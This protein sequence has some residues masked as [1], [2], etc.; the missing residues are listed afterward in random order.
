M[1]LTHRYRFSAS[2]RIHVESLSG[3]ENRRL[4]GKCNNPYGHGHN[5]NLEITVEGPVDAKTGRVVEPGELDRLVEAEVIAAYN[6]RYLNVDLP[7]FQKLTATTENLA[8]EIQRRLD[9]KWRQAFPSGVPSLAHIRVQETK[10][11]VFDL[12]IIEEAI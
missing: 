8:Y 12:S 9:E 6:H 5:Y 2:H 4:F 3:E 7:E 1:R 11:N 10:R